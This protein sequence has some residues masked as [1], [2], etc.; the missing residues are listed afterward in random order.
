MA[1]IIYPDGTQLTEHAALAAPLAKI[2]IRLRHW[3][4]PDT[5]SM[6]SLLNKTELDDEEKETLLAGVDE[7][8]EELKR[9]A[10]YRSRDLVV[11]HE[12]L[13][14]LDEMLA[15]FE[16][17][18]YHDDDEVRYTLA[19]SGYFGFVAD[20][21]QFMLEVGAGDYINVPAGTEHWFT[22]KSPRA[23]KAVRYF[24]DP[25]GWTPRYTGRPLLFD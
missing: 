11:V 15:K 23:I 8:F 14:Q 13:P 18:H 16:K 17:I 21:D 1:Q 25:A 20:G 2:G 10:G 3:P 4:V 12:G 22:L 6:R 19:G 9:S 5:P 24:I 7:R